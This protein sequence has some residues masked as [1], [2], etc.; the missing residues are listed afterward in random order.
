MSCSTYGVMSTPGGRNCRYSEWSKMP[1]GIIKFMITVSRLYGR[2]NC[3]TTA[4]YR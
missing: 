2:K 1:D 3:G 4:N